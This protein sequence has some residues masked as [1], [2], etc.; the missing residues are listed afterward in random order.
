[1]PNPNAFV[2]KINRLDREAERGAELELD[3]GRRVRLDPGD[4]RAAGYA[5]IIEGRRELGKPV[6]LEVDPQTGAITRL[7]LPW[8]TRI[9]SI[10]GT[11]SGD[12]SIVLPL[13]QAPH[14]LRRASPD[15]D[16]YA[17]LLQDALDRGL[18]VILTEDDRNDLIDLRLSPNPEEDLP[19]PKPGLPPEWWRRWPWYRWWPVRVVVDAARFIVKIISWWLT[20]V[21]QAKANEMFT[22]VSGLSC[23]PPNPV[24]PPCITFLYPKDGCYARAHEMCRLMGLQG[25]SS[26]KVFNYAGSYNDLYVQTK[27]SPFCSVNWWYHVAPTLRVRKSF[28]STEEQVIDPAL[29]TGPVT[30]TAWQAKQT[31]PNATLVSTDA[32]V[33]FRDKG[34]NLSYDPNYINTTADLKLLLGSLMKWWEDYGPPPYA[35]CP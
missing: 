21:T 6:Y 1:M 31:D 14:Y 7:E 4:R 11:P 15:F 35:N 32:S 8:V 13:S 10:E 5:Q 33:Y 9:L 17:G 16:A 30:T 25:V 29:F 34:G 20:A 18:P 27:N 3:D 22:M 19:F 2:G 12:L 28:P 23:L 26:K 24:T